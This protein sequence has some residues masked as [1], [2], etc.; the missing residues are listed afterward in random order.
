MDALQITGWRTVEVT[1]VERP[2]LSTSHVISVAPDHIIAPETCPKC[3]AVGMAVHT[4]HRTYEVVDT[5]MYGGPVKLR[6]EQARFRCHA[7]G[8]RRRRCGRTMLQPLPAELVPKTGLTARCIIYIRREQPYRPGEQVAE[9][10]GVNEATVRNL[11]KRLRRPEAEIPLTTRYLGVDEIELRD[12]ADPVAPFKRRKRAV[13]SDLEAGHVIALL[14]DADMQ[15]ISTQVLRLAPHIRGVAMDF[16]L[17]NRR[18]VEEAL[19]PERQKREDLGLGGKPVPIVIDRF[20]VEHRL[21]R[22]MDAVRVRELKALAKPSKDFFGKDEVKMLTQMLWA[23]AEPTSVASRNRFNEY[24]AHYP[25]TADAYRLKQEFKA[26]WS[27]RY[28]DAP[29]PSEAARAR[30]DAWEASFPDSVKDEF[31]VFAKFIRKHSDPVFRYFDL[32]ISNGQTERLNSAT[33]KIIR[34]SGRIHLATIRHKVLDRTRMAGPATHFICDE[35]GDRTPECDEERKTAKNPKLHPIDGG[36]MLLCPACKADPLHS[37][38]RPSRRPTPRRRR[39]V[40]DL[41]QAEMMLGPAVPA[42]MGPGGA[43]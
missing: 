9:S 41:P 12:L 15:T 35:C 26:L 34:N 28:R 23:K 37:S 43:P 4:G 16:S 21:H 36:A 39:S 42:T 19:A 10:I 22:A 5:P 1:A 40:P 13:L 18:A 31:S 24:L 32:G 2:G 30:F 11:M 6:F 14:D 33:R 20:H 8:P 27:E 29:S 25:D 7:P 17:S 3:G 38:P